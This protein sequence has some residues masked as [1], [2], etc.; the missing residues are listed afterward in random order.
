MTDFGTENVL[1][2]TCEAFA[3]TIS[4]KVA[5]FRRFVPKEKARTNPALTG[6]F[7]EQLV[8][9]FVQEWV[10]H[11]RLVQGTF[12]NEACAKQEKPALQIDGIVHDPTRGPPIIQEGDFEI[13]H[14]AFC[15]G[16]VEIKTTT[17][18]NDFEERLLT[19]YDRYMSHL[20]RP[21]VMGVVI[22]SPDPEKDSRV[23]LSDGRVDYLHNY[24]VVNWC[25][26]FIL[27]QET[28]GEYRPFF[29]AIEALIRAT[30][31]LVVTTNY[32]G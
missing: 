23:P 29:P 12:Y 5:Q 10:G 32:L 27:F 13:V 1:K 4:L 9:G 31:Q 8:R 17:R 14:P 11:Q 30:H 3:E 6:A 22:S 21:S 2:Y 18:I 15:S 19:I 26:V 16:V 20:T 25:P 28:D 7:I 24:A